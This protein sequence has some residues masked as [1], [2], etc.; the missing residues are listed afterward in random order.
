[1]VK[2]NFI[3]TVLL[4]VTV[5]LI[6]TPALAQKVRG[7]T[8]TEILIGQWGPQTGPAAP[9]G[10]VARGTDLLCKIVNEEGGINGRKI[11]YFLRDDAYQPAKTK[12]IVKE[13][14]EDI[15]V[16]TVIGGVGVAPGMTARDYLME[17]KVFWFAPVTGVYEWIRPFQKYLFAVYPLYD[18]EAYNLTGYLYEK[19][20]FKKIAMFYQNDDYG[21]QGL[22]GVDR[23]LK[24]KKIDL[25][26]KISAE[27]T[28]RDLSTHALK[29]RDSGAE[30]VVM[31]AMPTHAA[32]ILGETA[33]IGFK[34]Q[35]AT[36]NTLSDST[37]MMQITKGLWAGMI[38]SNF[39]ELPD[40]NLPLM[41]KYREWHKKLAPQERWGVFYLAGIVF[42]EPYFEG[43]RRAGKNLNNDTLM[44]SLEGLKDFRGIGGPVSYSPTERQGAKHVFYGKV[45]PDGSI[46]KITDW[47]RITK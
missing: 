7:V 30:A 46:E 20:G 29:L 38:H 11:K 31:W 9:W 28:D 47:I 5:F 16:F 13:F 24:D 19:L 4:T 35:W 23:Y 3:L 12:A 21:K 32:L 10:A 22:M 33:K 43:V 42:A 14:V 45:K 36:S 6:A 15:G 18:D 34:P 39:V 17:N 25:V 1:M 2:K 26:A 40:S 37:L 41:V 27:V 44:K 8:D